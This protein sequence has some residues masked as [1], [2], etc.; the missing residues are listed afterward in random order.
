MRWGRSP[1]IERGLATALLTNLAKVNLMAKPCHLQRSSAHG[2]RSWRSFT[3]SQQLLHRTNVGTALHHCLFQSTLQAF[4][5]QAIASLQA[6]AWNDGQ[7]GRWKHPKPSLCV[8]HL[9]TFD[10]QRATGIYTA[11]LCLP[12][13]LPQAARGQHLTSQRTFGERGSITT[14]SLLPLASCTTMARRSKSTFLTRRRRPS[15]LV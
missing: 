13:S 6:V 15:S 8:A 3:A 9:W 12:I 10:L 14:R 5:E 7:R 4:F 11:T 1:K 2:C